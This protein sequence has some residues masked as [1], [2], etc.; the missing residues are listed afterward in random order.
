M[1]RKMKSNRKNVRLRLLN[2]AFRALDQTMM[3]I[4]D[5]ALQISSITNQREKFRFFLL[6]GGSYQRR[7]KSL[8]STH[9]PRDVFVPSPALY[10]EKLPDA[11]LLFSSSFSQQQCIGIDNYSR[12][13]SSMAESVSRKREPSESSFIQP[14]NNKHPRGNLP[15][16]RNIPD[17][18]RGSLIPPQLKGSSHFITSMHKNTPLGNN[19][20]IGPILRHSYVFPSRKVIASKVSQSLKK[21]YLS[22][23]LPLFP[24]SVSFP[25]LSSPSPL[26]MTDNHLS[27]VHPG[28]NPLTAAQHPASPKSCF[29]PPVGGLPR[30]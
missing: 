23:L 5:F 13:A 30:A 20:K 18:V 22:Y 4:E 7:W 15:H 27:S 9:R 3:I 2:V 28:A 24:I 8:S 12:I 10:M 29:F 17:T 11:S 6:G 21:S 26:L 25:S 1:T 19:Q 14:R 16:S